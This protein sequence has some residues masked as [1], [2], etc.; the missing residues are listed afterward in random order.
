MSLKILILGAGYGTRL[1]RDILNDTSKKY[2]HLQGVPK[3]L[4]PLNG[5]ALITRWLDTLTESN[6]DLTTSV[7]VVTNL[8]SYSSFVSW[9]KSNNIPTKNIVNDGSTSN[10][11]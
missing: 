5:K 1:Q 9:A 2:S 7:Y 6:I 11:N 4:L 10:E 8:P 3:A